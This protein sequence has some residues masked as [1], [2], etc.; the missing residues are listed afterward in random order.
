MTFFSLEPRN[1]K[2]VLKENGPYLIDHI[3]LTAILPHLYAQHMLTDAEYEELQMN[4]VAEHSRIMRLLAILPKKGKSGLQRFL[5]ALR[6][7]SDHL[8]HQEIAEKLELHCKFSN[9]H[10]ELN[11][12]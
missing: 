4:T 7:S 9:V 3:N 5:T 8:S 2:T 11:S 12:T 10:A 1:F 6:N